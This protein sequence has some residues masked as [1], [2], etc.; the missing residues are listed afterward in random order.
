MTPVARESRNTLFHSSGF[1]RE[2]HG[3]RDCTS[4][5]QRYHAKDSVKFWRRA[6][7]LTLVRLLTETPVTSLRYYESGTNASFRKILLGLETTHD[8]RESEPKHRILLSHDFEKSHL[9]KGRL[10]QGFSL[11]NQRMQDGIHDNTT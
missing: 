2:I 4:G 6:L 7:S 3:G 9:R 5:G 10:W 11:Y 8:P 1:R